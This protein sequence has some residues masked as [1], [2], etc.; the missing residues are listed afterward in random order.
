MKK[1]ISLISVILLGL[2]AWMVLF[3]TACT[4]SGTP[5]TLPTSGTVVPTSTPTKT[6]TPVITNTPVVT[7]T[8]GG[9]TS[10]PTSTPNAA[11]TI[12]YSNGVFAPLGGCGIC[13]WSGGGDATATTN[14]TDTIGGYGADTMCWSNSWATGSLVGGGWSGAS[15]ANS[16]GADM[17]AFT[18]CT[19]Y[20]YANQAN[21]EAFNACPPMGDNATVAKSLTTSWQQFT[22]QFGSPR[23]D[24]YGGANTLN[25]LSCY[26]VV[27]TPNIPSTFP[28]V[29]YV[30]QIVFQ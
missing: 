7:N 4:I 20:A 11:A 1:M 23:D 29:S 9:A 5:V 14:G 30:D 12:I 17:S 25:N 21:T 16:V 26:F 2:G 22:I 8:P 13:M 19:F 27:G 24:G 3:H 28:F 10:T 6:N 18:T 15:A